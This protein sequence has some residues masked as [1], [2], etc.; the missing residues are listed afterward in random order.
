MDIK[1]RKMIMKA[2]ITSQ[3][4]YCP[5]IWI[6]HSTA[7]NNKISTIHERSLRITYNGRTSTFEFELLRKDKSVTVHHRNLQVLVTELYKVENNMDPEIADQVFQKR[8][9]SYNLRAKS[10]FY[11]RPVHSVYNGT[12]SLSFPGPKIWELVPEDAKQSETLEVFKNKI[13]KWV[14]FRCPCRLCRV[15]LQNIGFI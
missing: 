11:T 5:L 14:L 1:K 7:L 13:K 10:N 3:F 15:Y 9:S 6:F 2:Y 4:S 8:T 12:E